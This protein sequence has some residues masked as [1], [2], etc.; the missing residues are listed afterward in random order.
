MVTH[1]VFWKLKEDDCKEENARCI[2]E[3]LEALVGVV[4]G[5]LEMRVGLN[6]NG[7]E[8]DLALCSRFESAAAL[9]G[10]ETHPEHLRVRAFVKR[11]VVG[12]AA[13]DFEE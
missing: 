1:M 12:R 8:Y 2:K 4:P 7:G 13:V 11:V 6:V 5:L 9:H 3:G 10:Y